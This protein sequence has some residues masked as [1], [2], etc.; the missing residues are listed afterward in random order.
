MSPARICA[1]CHER[2][3][4][5]ERGRILP[6][7]LPNGVRCG[8]ALQRLVNA[9][10]PAPARTTSPI[11]RLLSRGGHVI[12]E[13][14]LSPGAPLRPVVRWIP[15]PEQLLEVESS[16]PLISF[17]YVG[18]VTESGE[19]FHKYTEFAPGESDAHETGIGEASITQSTASDRTRI[20]P[21]ELAPS[22]FD[23][24]FGRSTR[25]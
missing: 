25:H 7:E 15:S 24:L 23:R 12:D 2:C 17:Y 3:P 5:D 11:A 22:L 1:R 14:T 20:D 10:S 13:I 18:L 19:T 9:W 6:H 16:N 8:S 21:R 4:C